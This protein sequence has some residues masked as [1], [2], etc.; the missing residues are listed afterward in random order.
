MN[1]NVNAI[2]TVKEKID[3][4]KYGPQERW[5]RENGFMRIA[6]NPVPVPFVNEFKRICEEQGNSYASTISRLLK[7]FI[8]DPSIIDGI[9][10]HHRR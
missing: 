1:E 5:K 2:T 10:H 7:L 6:F 9:T 8:S 4:G 3:T